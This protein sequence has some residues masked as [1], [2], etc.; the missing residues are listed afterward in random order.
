[1]SAAT[2]PGDLLVVRP[3]RV[4]RVAVVAAVAIAATFTV[5][6]LFLTGDATGVY[7]RPVDQGAMI[8]FGFLLGGA[9]LLL[10]RPRLRVDRHGV[11]VRNV[12]GE[13]YFAWS[14]I[15][16]VSFPR[17]APWARLELPGDEYV[18]IMAIQATDGERAVTAIAALRAIRDEH[19]PSPTPTGTTPQQ[20]STP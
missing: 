17:D 15:E 11:G 5:L 19:L 10:A 4:R 1:M 3:H 7:F 13:Q 18:A 6:A 14:V 2:P 8:V 20:R 9:V 12:F 16:T